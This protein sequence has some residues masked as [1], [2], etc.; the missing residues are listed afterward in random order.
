MPTYCY[1]TDDGMTVER[2][3]RAGA[4]PQRIKLDTGQIAQRDYA[5]EICG[6]GGTRPGGWPYYSDQLSVL[7]KQIKEFTEFDRA[8]GCETKYDR[9][10]RPLIRDRHHWSR[11]LRARGKFDRS[12]G[13]PSP[14]NL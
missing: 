2:F 5:A 6:T 13:G 3:Y 12:G 10:G 9:E 4:Q 7:P 14:R 11:M 1:S 8:H